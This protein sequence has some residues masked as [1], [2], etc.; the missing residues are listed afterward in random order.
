MTTDRQKKTIHRN[1]TGRECRVVQE[2]WLS[3]HG[4]QLKFQSYISAAG[5]SS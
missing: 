3:S 2:G 1:K 5:D 4:W